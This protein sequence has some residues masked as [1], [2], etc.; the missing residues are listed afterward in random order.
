M[1]NNAPYGIVE[2]FEKFTPFG[3]MQLKRVL[4]M[5]KALSWKE[6]TEKQTAPAMIQASKGSFPPHVSAKLLAF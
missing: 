5:M 3:E 6:Q 4:A 1:H 2:F